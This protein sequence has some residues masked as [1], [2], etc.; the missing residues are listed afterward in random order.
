MLDDPVIRRDVI[1]AFAAY[2]DEKLADELLLRYPSFTG[3]EKLDVIHTLSA[4]SASGWKLTMA[5]KD[6]VVPRRD[7]PAYVARILQRV[8][9]NGFVE[10]W[11]PV[12]SVA[13]E[14]QAE[15]ERISN[16]LANDS[17]VANLSNGRALFNRT[18]STCHKLF[19]YGREI[20]PDITGANREDTNYLLGN[21]LTPSADIQDDYRMSIILM[22]DGRVYSGVVADEDERLVRLRVADEPDPVPLPKSAIESRRLSTA[23][24]M[25]DGILDNFTDDEIVDLIHYLKNEKQVELPRHP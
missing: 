4:R 13:P 1:R 15:I 23:S 2:D 11:G 10:V 14:R 9:G 3:E 25:P 20:G 21:I 16:L 7:V 18:C 24:M 17:R 12:E 19:G 8:V 22:D 6:E 5:I